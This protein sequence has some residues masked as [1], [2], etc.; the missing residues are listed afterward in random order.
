M[1]RERKKPFF[2]S[3]MGDFRLGWRESNPAPKSFKAAISNA[4]T[5]IKGLNIGVDAFNRW[6]FLN[7]GDLDGQWQLVRSWDMK[8]KKFLTEASPEP[9]AYFGFGILTRFTAKYSE[10]LECQVDET[11]S[12]NRDLLLFVTALRS[13]VN[14]NIT[15]IL[16]NTD[17]K[18]KFNA[19]FK[20]EKLE[21]PCRF[22]R[23]RVTESRINKKDFKLEPQMNF[24]LL[25]NSADFSDDILPFSITVY[26]TFELKHCD[27]GIIID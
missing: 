19:N 22:Y 9:V 2:L 5:V 20:F 18:A 25:P 14:K 23:Y 10:I 3:E 8:A 16:L 27:T 26:S 11:E 6:S 4:H 17:P 15:V 13:P 21:F 24:S 12:S 1:A 7:R